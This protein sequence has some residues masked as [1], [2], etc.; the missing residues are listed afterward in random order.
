MER[1]GFGIVMAC[2]FGA[3]VAMAHD[4]VSR[5]DAHMERMQ[6]CMIAKRHAL[7]IAPQEA[8]LLCEKEDR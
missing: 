8:Y 1:I 5:N 3:W 4:M 6:H 7:D 2:I